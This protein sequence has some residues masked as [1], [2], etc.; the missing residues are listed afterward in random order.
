MHMVELDPLKHSLVGQ[1]G[2]TGLALEARKVS[3]TGGCAVGT[4]GAAGTGYS[5]MHCLWLGACIACFGS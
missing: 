2:L 3:G 1:P 4:P 5:G